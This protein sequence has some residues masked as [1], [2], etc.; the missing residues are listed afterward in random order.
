MHV[1]ADTDN[2]AVIFIINYIVFEIAIDAKKAFPKGDIIL[3]F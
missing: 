2:E 1:A 3:E